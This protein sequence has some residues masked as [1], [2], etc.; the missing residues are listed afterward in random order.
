MNKTLKRTLAIALT[1]V[2]LTAMVPMMASA[3]PVNDLP[4]NS[5]SEGVDIRNSPRDT[6]RGLPCPRP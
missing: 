5:K 1:L 2:M 3:A 4:A 6:P